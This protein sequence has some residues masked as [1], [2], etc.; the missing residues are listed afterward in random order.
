MTKEKFGS[1]IERV[2]G[3]LFG[4][5]N[6]VL[7]QVTCEVDACLTE[8]D[9]LQEDLAETNLSS[10]DLS[11]VKVVRGMKNPPEEFLSPN[12]MS[13]NL[14]TNRYR[15]KE[16]DSLDPVV[17]CTNE[18]YF[19]IEYNYEGEFVCLPKDQLSNLIKMLQKAEKD[20][21]EGKI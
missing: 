15:I 6:E 3:R 13:S 5:V 21:K 7:E 10:S 14:K 4:K 11:G 8:L 1:R 2:T 18:R 20:I 16:N 19:A 12:W 17:Y 9:D